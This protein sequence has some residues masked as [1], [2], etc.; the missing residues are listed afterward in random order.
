MI[1]N[2][3]L[4]IMNFIPPIIYI[5]AVMIMVYFIVVPYIKKL[6]EERK[7]SKGLLWLLNSIITLFSAAYLIM[8]L[9]LAYN[10]F[11]VKASFS[12]M[13]TG[14]PSLTGMLPFFIHLGAAVFYF[15][16]KQLWMKVISSIGAICTGIFLLNLI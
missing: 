6:Q 4:V 7:L 9:L 14:R 3:L 12:I 1:A 8:I 10:N 13:V 11:V 16:T 15:R 2:S 5:L